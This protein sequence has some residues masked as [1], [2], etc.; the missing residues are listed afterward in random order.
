MYALIM[1]GGSGTR[2]WPVSRK[3]KPKQLLGLI[4]KQTLL[5]STFRR[6]RKGF[7]PKKIM[8][9]TGERYASA[10]RG[11]L[12]GV[13]K[14]NYLLEPCARD[15]GPALCLS[16]MRLLKRDRNATFVT[17]W[18]DHHIQNV[19]GFHRTLR[20]AERIVGEHPGAIVAIGVA[21]QYPHPG[22]GHLELGKPLD[23][24][25]GNGRYEV[26][27]FI[28]KPTAKEATAMTA[29]GRCL[30]NTGYFVCRADTVVALCRRYAPSA[31]RVLKQIEPHLGTSRERAAVARLYP[32]V[33][34]FDLEQEA[35]VKLSGKQLLAVRG[36]FDWIDIGSWKI[37]KDVQSASGEN[38]TL[39][40][41]T[42]AEGEDNLVYNYEPKLVAL[43]GLSD[44]VVVNTGD[45]LLV[46]TKHES[47]KIKDLIKEIE[48]QKR[49]E[50]YL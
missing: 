33:P 12:P 48:K 5:Q 22:F 10:I 8:L 32:K 16:A 17:I 6:I 46:T 42:V 7:P 41:V 4:G 26:R 31:Y 15:L 13:P 45:A 29:S 37:L 49:L 1:A 36:D 35:F 19:T 47:E 40:N 18:S 11:Q 43:Y 50:R 30:W 2:L 38:L 24:R 21:P 25:R 14:S 44:V 9:S 3:S 27:R 23:P 34:K 28:R 39:G 20:A